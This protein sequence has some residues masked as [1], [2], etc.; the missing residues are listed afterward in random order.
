MKISPVP[1]EA[2]TKRF[3]QVKLV[4]YVI[5]HVN[6]FILSLIMSLI[7]FWF[8]ERERWMDDSQVFHIRLFTQRTFIKHLVHAY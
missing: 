5:I 4:L 3:Y 7:R 2:P 8:R 6:I 1:W